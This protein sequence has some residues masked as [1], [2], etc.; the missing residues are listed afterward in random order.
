[1]QAPWYSYT[2]DQNFG[3]Y[4]DPL[5]G[6]NYPK[7]DT[8]FYGIPD[9]TAI[10]ALASGTVTGVRRMPWS[11]L[12]YSVTVQMDQPFNSVAKYTA[13]N[14]V[15][16]PTVSVGQHVNVGDTLAFSGNPYNIGTAFALV[17]TPIYGTGSSNEPFSGNYVN[18]ALNPVPF[19]Q[20]IL[21][22]G[23]G[24]GSLTTVLGENNIGTNNNNTSG[25][26]SFLG[27]DF[28]RFIDA[29]LLFVV[30]LTL[31]IVGAIMLLNRGASVK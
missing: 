25:T 18:P 30:G 5:P 17:D 22:N 12:A 2:Y 1:M 27:F 4:P 24:G 20:S 13:Y 3:T 29:G 19:L 8:N 10:T 6:A 31:V 28:T 23:G 14:Y 15:S 7:P 21:P 11:P 9:G 16:N 26:N